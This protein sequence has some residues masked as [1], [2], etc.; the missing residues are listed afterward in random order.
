M[1]F[2]PPDEGY[3]P[4]ARVSEDSFDLGQR[5]E[6]GESKFVEQE[7]GPSWNR[8]TI[9]MGLTPKIR[10]TPSAKKEVIIIMPGLI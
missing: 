2:F 7:A 6:S 5:A 3:N 10:T 1:F 8:H 4:S 9:I